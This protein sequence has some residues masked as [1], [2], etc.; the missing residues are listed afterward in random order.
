MIATK[1]SL[2]VFVSEAGC[3][4]PHRSVQRKV[5]N[6]VFQLVL[7]PMNTTKNDVLCYVN[8]EVKKLVDGTELSV[9]SFQRMWRTWFSH[10]QIPPFS[11]FSKCYLC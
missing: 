7:L 9:S 2:D 8:E 10:L 4:Q 1:E 11:R 3:Q 5:D 6:V